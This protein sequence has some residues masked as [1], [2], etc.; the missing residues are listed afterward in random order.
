MSLFPLYEAYLRH[1]KALH[2]S[3]VKL[4]P[5]SMFTRKEYVA[6]GAE[7][8]E[9]YFGARAK[10]IPPT[11]PRY[12]FTYARRLLSVWF[13]TGLGTGEKC[14]SDRK[15]DLRWGNLDWDKFRAD[16]DI[17]YNTTIHEKS[18]PN[19]SW[20]NLN[21]YFVRNAGCREMVFRTYFKYMEIMYNMEVKGDFSFLAEMA[22]GATI[23]RRILEGETERPFGPRVDPSEPV[24][25]NFLDPEE[26]LHR[27]VNATEFTDVLFAGPIGSF[28]VWEG[29][30]DKL[31][32]SAETKALFA[33]M[34]MYTFVNVISQDK[35]IRF[36]VPT[37]F[38]P[39]VMAKVENGGKLGEAR[40]FTEGRLKRG[41]Y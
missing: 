18:S 22:V 39:A 14:Q 30:K 6:R 8:V 5:W 11:D 27:F 29:Y 23:T 21:L 40:K 13:C 31:W 3:V 37:T 20:T 33:E 41:P 1:F 9:E 26:T 16:M 10:A 2:A 19:G 35:G 12:I 38:L 28:L 15:D 34:T 36:W 24:L 32:E 7:A 25:M 17:L 4:V